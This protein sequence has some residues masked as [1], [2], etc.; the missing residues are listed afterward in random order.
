MRVFNFNK[1]KFLVNQTCLNVDFPQLSL[2][3]FEIGKCKLNNYT[4]DQNEDLS[5]IT[6]EK[7]VKLGFNEVDGC[8]EK[9]SDTSIYYTSNLTYSCLQ[10]ASSGIVT[11]VSF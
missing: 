11:D 9:I 3:C 8:F 4:N 2:Q 1:L 6:G 5:L 7:V 10:E